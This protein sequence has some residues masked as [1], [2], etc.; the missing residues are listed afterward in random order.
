MLKSLGEQ[1]ILEK[2]SQATVQGTLDLRQRVR[3]ED[4]VATEIQYELARIRVDI[5]TVQNYNETVKEALVAIDDDVKFKFSLISKMQ[6]EIRR[7]H[8]EVEMKTKEIDRLNK[9]Y[10]KLTANM[11]DKDTTPWEHIIHKLGNEINEK[12]KASSELQ[13][14]WLIIQTALVSVT[15]EDNHLTEEHQQKET[16]KTVLEQRN[17]RL[18]NQFALLQ[19]NV[20]DLDSG[21]RFKHHVITRYDLVMPVVV[22]GSTCL[23]QQ[24]TFAHN[25]KW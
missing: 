5:L 11:V 10:E 16:E 2:S 17:R 13:K 7:R 1:I 23:S 4:M 19:K 3:A 24:S 21:V 15:T 22:E 20:K 12:V 9:Q 6:T 25:I 18:D 8:G 14:Q